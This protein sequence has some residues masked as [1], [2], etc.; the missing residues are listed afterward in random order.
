MHTHTHTHTQTKEEV[1]KAKDREQEER[2]QV[3]KAVERRNRICIAIEVR[4][5]FV[6]FPDP[7]EPDW[8]A[9]HW[10]MVIVVAVVVII[11]V[12]VITNLSL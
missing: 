12:I 11:I 8:A 6:R 10:S 1:G 9:L 4:L 5:H 3:Y 2:R 7:L